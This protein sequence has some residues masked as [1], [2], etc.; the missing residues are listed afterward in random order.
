MKKNII[1][2]AV[3]SVL[4]LVLLP[5]AVVFFIGGMDALGILLLM[6]FILNPIVS[7]VI[8]ILSGGLKT[9][10][11]LS[12]INAAVFLSA[13]SIILGFDISYII[14]AVICLG[15]GLAAAYVTAA[16]KKK[17][18]VDYKIENI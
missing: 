8:G 12:A 1:I 4:T 3:L 2:S 14:A 11:Q 13:E 10:W 15:L 9:K 7:V 16:V 17:K 5:L 6:F 18:A